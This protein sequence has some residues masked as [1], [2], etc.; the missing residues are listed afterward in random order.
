MLYTPQLRPLKRPRRN[1]NP[2]TSKRP[3]L[4]HDE[5]EWGSLKKWEVPGLRQ[6]MF[7]RSLEDLVVVGS[8]DGLG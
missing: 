6:T 1:D 8:K 3:S 7:R 5:K 4:L 2:G